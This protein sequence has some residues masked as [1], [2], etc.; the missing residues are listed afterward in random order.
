MR[1]FI[2]LPSKLKEHWIGISIIVGLIASFIQIGGYNMQTFWN[3]LF[4]IPSV[5]PIIDTIL[6]LIAI[7][8]GTVQKTK[9]NEA[10]TDNQIAKNKIS[11]LWDFINDLSECPYSDGR[12][13]ERQKPVGMRCAVAKNGKIPRN[14]NAIITRLNEKDTALGARFEKLDQELR[15][16]GFID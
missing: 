4:G 7:C 6:A 2:N 15:E 9:Y 13:F 5:V 16:N 10:V 8:W 11:T 14:S 12:E 3:N 1:S